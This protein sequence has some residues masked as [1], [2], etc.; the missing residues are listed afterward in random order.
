MR[1][2]TS[3]IEKGDIIQTFDNKT[4]VVIDISPR[5]I[6]LATIDGNITIHL[7]NIQKLRYNPPRCLRHFKRN[8]E[9][10]HGI[11]HEWENI[12]EISNKDFGELDIKTLLALF[13]L[14]QNMLIKNQ[15]YLKER[16]DKND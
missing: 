14:N 3:E 9:I 16:L 2:K 1:I 8:C 7:K 5:K 10:C 15:K 4:G 12:V 13:L 11:K 6:I